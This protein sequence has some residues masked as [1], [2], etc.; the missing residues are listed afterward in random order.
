[1]GRLRPGTRNRSVFEAAHIYMPLTFAAS[2]SAFYLLKAA[3]AP[4]PRLRLSQ[5]CR[6]GPSGS[7]LSTHWRR[8]S[9][10]DCC[11]CR[12][13]IGIQHPTLR[14]PRVFTDWTPQGSVPDKGDDCRV[15][16]LTCAGGSQSCKT[17]F[18]TSERPCVWVGQLRFLASRLLPL[19]DR[20]S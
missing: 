10:H 4:L 14:N 12:S 8:S 20:R 6:R 18:M 3:M 9:R 11:E 7:A 1:M 17:S 2:G 13:R 15:P 19:P 5:K 16:P